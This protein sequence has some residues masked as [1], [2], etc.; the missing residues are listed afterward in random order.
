[1]YRRRA[2]GHGQVFGETHRL[3]KLALGVYSLVI[4]HIVSSFLEPKVEYVCYANNLNLVLI[5]YFNDLPMLGLNRRWRLIC[6][7]NYFKVVSSITGPFLP[8]LPSH[9]LTF[10]SFP[11]LFYP[12][13]FSS[14][15][16]IRPPRLLHISIFS[17]L[18][19]NSSQHANSPHLFVYF[20]KFSGEP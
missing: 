15:Y 2:G 11:S 7:P 16:I 9:F 18:T 14:F 4:Y 12:H 20:L 19:L 6:V 3:I 8:S 1:M 10:L 13:L 17:T 5:I